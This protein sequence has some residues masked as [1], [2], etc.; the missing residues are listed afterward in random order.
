MT[1]LARTHQI[2]LFAH[3]WEPDGTQVCFHRVP[4]LAWPGILRFLSFYFLASRAVRKAAKEH[5]EFAGVYSPGPNCSEVDV[6]GASF[7]Q[8][9]QL[10]FIRSGKHRPP[11]ASAKDALKLA[12]RWAYA[13][14]VS[15]LEEAFYRNP[16]LKRVVTPSH[17]LARDL[18]HYYGLPAMK[19]TVSPA[20]VNTATFHAE[21]RAALRQKARMSLGISASEFAFFFIG[22]NWMVKGLYHLMRAM[23]GAPHARV[24]VVGLGEEDPESWQRLA[25]TE[26]VADRIVFL[27]RRADVIFYYAAADCLV[28]PSVYDTFALMPLE[29]MACGLPVILS[30]NTGVAE[31]VGAEDCLV[32]ENIED[33]GEMAQAMSRMANDAGLRARLSANGLALARRRSWDGIYQAIAEE[34][35]G[36]ESVELPK[37]A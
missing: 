25:R 30:R 16:S 26:G 21:G 24:F 18:A 20:G 12:H 23:R 13:W 17:L 6:C 31:I 8:A 37:T 33:L 36:K 11:L 28:V 4:V 3:H 27:P 34:L 2:C 14:I 22:N 1:R 5:G 9:R 15:R 32:V 19:I 7:C 35:L 29:A 10:G